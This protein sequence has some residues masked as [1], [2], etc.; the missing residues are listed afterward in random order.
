MIGDLAILAGIVVIAG[1]AGVALGMLLSRPLSRL[2]D[3]GS[4]EDEDPVDGPD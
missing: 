3:R 4:A 1:L 2:A